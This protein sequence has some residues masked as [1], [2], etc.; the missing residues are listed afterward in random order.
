[1]NNKLHKTMPPDYLYRNGVGIML[2]NQE[3][4]IFIGKRI[5]SYDNSEAWQMPQGGIDIGEEEEIAMFR[6]LQEETGVNKKSVKIISRT[7]NYYYYNLP[8]QLQKKL[9]NGKY[10][11]QKQRWYIL[12]L[13]DKDSAINIKTEHPEFIDWKWSN[14]E[15]VIELIIDFKK[16][17]Y[18][19]VMNIFNK[20]LI[21]TN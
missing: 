17:L 1:M 13:E 4:K 19:D 8:P 15:E 11:G 9:W 2:I 12:Q 21:N 6:E 5:D 3:K 20:F 16:D 14:K 18:R 10:L 7:P